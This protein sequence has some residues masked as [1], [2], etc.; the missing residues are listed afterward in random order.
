MGVSRPTFSQIV[1]AAHRKVAD[2]IVHGKKKMI[3]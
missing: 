2:A 1:E 3:P